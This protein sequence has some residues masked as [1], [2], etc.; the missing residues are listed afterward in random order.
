[1]NSAN[2]IQEIIQFA[3]RALHLGLQRLGS[4]IALVV[5]LLK[6][7]LLLRYLLEPLRSLFSFFLQLVVLPFKISHIDIKKAL[8]LAHAGPSLFNFIYSCISSLSHRILHHFELFTHSVKFPS[9]QGLGH[10]LAIVLLPL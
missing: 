4:Q 6:D 3:L 2:R 1:M 9:I 5:L 8:F 10:L 7:T